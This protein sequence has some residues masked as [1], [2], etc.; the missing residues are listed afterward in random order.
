MTIARLLARLLAA[1]WVLGPGLA[2]LAGEYHVCG[3]GEEGRGVEVPG[4]TTA[5][6]CIL[7]TCSRG[8][9]VC[10]N[11][12][13]L[14]PSVKGCSNLAPRPP[15]ECCDTCAG[16]SLNNSLSLKSGETRRGHTQ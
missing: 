15:G 13:R 14:C 3:G 6:P 4:I 10:Q 9:V 8:R 1:A 12:R 2:Q 7:C 16:C 5:D 11:K